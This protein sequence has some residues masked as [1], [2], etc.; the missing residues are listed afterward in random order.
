MFPELLFN[1]V[2]FTGAIVTILIARARYGTWLTTGLLYSAGWIA[3]VIF[4]QY[5]NLVLPEGYEIPS[6]SFEFGAKLVFWGYVG[7]ILGHL[8]FGP[9]KV[10]YREFHNYFSDLG[11]F[12]DKYHMWICGAVFALGFIA[13]VEKVG[14]VGL[15]I[16]TLADL[17]H[18][19]V[20][21]RFTLFQRLGVYGSIILGLFVTFSAIDDNLKG[22]VNVRRIIAIIVALL[23]LALS[24]GSR[25]EFMNPIMGYAITNFLV[26]QLRLISGHS[27]KW[28]LMSK[29]YAKFLPLCLILLFTFTVYGQLRQVGSK[30]MAGEY[31]MF[32]LV[33]AP[34]QLSVSIASWFASSFYSLGPI[35]EFEDVT[36]PRMHGRI[37]F[38]PIFKVPEKLGLI[39]D[40]SVLV[41]FARQDAFDQFGTAQ[42][43]FTPGTMGKVLTREVGRDLAPYFAALAMFVAVAIS[44]KWRRNSLFGFIV[45]SLFSSQA[46]MSFQTLRGINM[47]VTWQL[48][49][50]MMFAYW[51]QEFRRKRGRFIV[52]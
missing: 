44:N 45:V 32:A 5:L 46:L 19:H 30:K 39:N 49:F 33:D 48:I 3:T 25:Q 6:S 18:E 41:Y 16:F 2:V 37:Y 8:F 21:S 14:S 26:I 38:E 34:L 9:P 12:L 50:A 1:V 43:A 10:R 52:R 15:N 29:M 24:K 17:R 51:Y 47:I 22:R 40:K 20:N 35:T 36:F 4:Y 27:I 28:R 13:L 31:S 23:P 42:I 7:V 11:Y